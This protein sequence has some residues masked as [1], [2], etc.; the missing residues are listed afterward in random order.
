M[1][2]NR[3]QPSSLSPSA[4]DSR[5]NERMSKSRLWITM[6]FLHVTTTTCHGSDCLP[7]TCMYVIQGLG[8]TPYS[9]V[10]EGW[11]SVPPREK[12]NCPGAC[13]PTSQHLEF[14]SLEE[15]PCPA[16]ELREGLQRSRLQRGTLLSSGHP[17][18]LQGGGRGA[19]VAPLT[20]MIYISIESMRTMTQM[21]SYMA[22][23]P[24]ALWLQPVLILTLF[25]K[26]D[27]NTWL[28]KIVRSKH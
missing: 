19:Y 15:Q 22:N 24:Q 4:L 27:G 18:K 28:I 26:T 12:E 8:P 13:F 21:V 25:F 10:I 5:T 7:V 17:W 14:R 20:D 1:C 3:K 16:D 11:M 6:T 2:R 23:T 9:A